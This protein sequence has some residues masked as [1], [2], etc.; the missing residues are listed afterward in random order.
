MKPNPFEEII[1]YPSVFTQFKSEHKD[2]Y[3]LDE[4]VNEMRDLANKHAVKIV[5]AESPFK[6]E[7]E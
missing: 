2:D 4:I 1:D 7:R 6:G 3:K 5:C